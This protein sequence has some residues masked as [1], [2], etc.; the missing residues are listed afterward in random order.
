MLTHVLTLSKDIY[1]CDFAK[2]LLGRI[3]AKKNPKLLLALKHEKNRGCGLLCREK[4]SSAVHVQSDCA[5]G[6]SKLAMLIRHLC[7]LCRSL[8]E[9]QI[10][11]GQN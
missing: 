2:P 8:L 5:F 11:T 3:T 1:S 6:K 7:S 9:V 4:A 10:C